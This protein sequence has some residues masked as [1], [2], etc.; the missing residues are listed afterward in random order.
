LE[1]A[2]PEKY[3]SIWEAL[4]EEN[5]YRDK[6]IAAME[7]EVLT[8]K[9]RG[10]F[11]IQSSHT[12]TRTQRCV[13]RVGTKWVITTK[14]DV[15]KARLVVLGY[16]QDKT[17]LYTYAPTMRKETTRQVFAKA[18][19]H[20]Y[21]IRS[22][23]IRNA[24]IKED[25]T[26]DVFIYVPSYM[27]TLLDMDLSEVDRIQLGKMLY[28]M[29]D[30][31]V[32]FYDG[33]D[34]HLR[35]HALTRSY[36]D[37]CHFH[38]PG[39]DIGFHVD[40]GA[41]TGTDDEIKAFERHM[42][43]HYELKDVGTCKK[44]TGLRAVQTNS[45]VYVHQ[46]PYIEMLI[47]N[48]LDASVDVNY[49]RTAGTPMEH[50]LKLDPPTSDM[51][52]P[53]DDRHLPFKE[54]R[55]SLM[56]VA[57]GTRP[58]IAYAVSILG[59]F[60]HCYNRTLYKYLL[61]IL[62]YLKGSIRKCILYSSRREDCDIRSYTVNFPPSTPPMNGIAADASCLDKENRYRGRGGYN[63]GTRRPNRVEYTFFKGY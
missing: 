15:F 13:K 18:A 41:Y 29:A 35:R 4:S 1:G 10:T 28:G 22:L 53:I 44:F 3:K 33:L 17:D 54:L 21:K 57:S 9:L 34:T 60:D 55:C 16:M 39:I 37:P 30:S 12:W 31:P 47:E 59:A 49:S 5:P 14:E 8:L 48:Y 45:G 24:F 40:D 42:A 36:S 46:I 32:T 52:T 6:V 61:R 26:N 51:I 56:W 50:G 62:K 20:G 23:D 38:R 2:P 7:L 11:N 27:A 58:D 63:Y 25:C 19:K 43:C